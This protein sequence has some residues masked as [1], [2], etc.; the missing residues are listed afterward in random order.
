[1]DTIENYCSERKIKEIDF[2][3]IDTEGHKL[4]IL[5][6]GE[7]LFKKRQIKVIQFEYGGYNIDS[8]VLLEDIFNFS[9]RLDYYFYKI[10]PTQ[11]K[12]IKK[13]DCRFENFQSQNWLIFWN[14]YVNYTY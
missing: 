14:D 7:S 11:L 12:L 5:K 3:K 1:M 10:F 6:G 9:N 2:V 4:E 8:L 13:Y